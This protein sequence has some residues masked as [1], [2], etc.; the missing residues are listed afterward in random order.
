MVCKI[1]LVATAV[2]DGANALGHWFHL[3]SN[4]SRFFLHI[5]FGKWKVPRCQRNRAVVVETAVVIATHCFR[6]NW[7][8]AEHPEW[9]RC[10][11]PPLKTT[12]GLSRCY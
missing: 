5:S 3:L 12:T 2:D 9:P 6:S 1:L 7:T 8:S 11:S 4:S 10:T